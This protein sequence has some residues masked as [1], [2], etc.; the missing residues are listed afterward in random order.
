MFHQY[1]DQFQDFQKSIEQ[2]EDVCKLAVDDVSIPTN[3]MGY[4]SRLFWAS[5]SWGANGEAAEAIDR[6][7]YLTVDEPAANERAAQRAQ[8]KAQE[9]AALE[10]EYNDALAENAALKRQ[11]AAQGGHIRVTNGAT[12]Y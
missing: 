1:M 5:D 8:E 9:R 10:A 3:E 11:E 2:M 4:F 12:G 7:V 6:P